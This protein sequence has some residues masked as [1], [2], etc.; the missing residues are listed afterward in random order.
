MPRLSVMLVTTRLHIGGEELSTLT[1]ARELKRR[2]HHVSWV[3]TDGPLRKEVE[4][5]GIPL[6]SATINRRD[7][8]GV[9][10]GSLALRRLMSHERIHIIHCQSVVPAIMASLGRPGFRGY[11]PRIIWHDRGVKDRT[12]AVIARLCNHLIDF[13]IT[14]SDYEKGKLLRRGMRPQKV[15]TIHNC[16]NLPFPQSVAKPKDRD[17]LASLG[18]A[19]SD[20]VIGTVGRLHPFKGG[21]DQLLKAVAR[22]STEILNCKLL[23]VGTGPVQ[24]DLVNLAKSLG[25]ES[26]TIFTGVRRDLARLY[27]IMDVF[28]LPSTWESFG[29]VLV[30]AMAHAKPVVATRVGGIPEAVTD[31]VTGILVPPG[32]PASLAEAILTLARDQELAARLGNAG[33]ARVKDYFSP[34]R[35]GDELE[36]L[37]HSLITG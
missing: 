36:A 9:L 32:D 12:Y 13:V 11:K 21:H 31:G 37:Y 29:N 3:S 6:I 35:L 28:V 7:P 14:N 15:G 23:V 19:E 2:G 16:L 33:R 25:I 24:A 22:V 4:E 17:M 20:V 27:P 18:V 1:I 5:A 26:R 10:L 34:T 30:E 8:Y